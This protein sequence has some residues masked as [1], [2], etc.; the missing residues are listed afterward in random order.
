MVVPG[1]YSDSDDPSV[2]TYFPID[3]IVSMFDMCYPRVVS[4]RLYEHRP[5]YSA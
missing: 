4:L 3:L 2:V 1:M 5:H